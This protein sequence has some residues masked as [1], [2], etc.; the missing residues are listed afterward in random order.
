MNWD[1][2]YIEEYDDAKAYDDVYYASHRDR[3][4]L[5]KSAE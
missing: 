3:S 1:D 2:E 4:M 5:D